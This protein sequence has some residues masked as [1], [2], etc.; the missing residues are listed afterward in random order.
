[1]ESNEFRRDMV[2]LLPR[3]RRFAMTLTR[4]AADA[5]HLVEQACDRAISRNQ[6]WSGDGHFENWL[7]ALTRNVWIDEVRKQKLQASEIDSARSTLD[8]VSQA[9]RMHQMI[10][11]LPEGL[12]TVF[13]LVNVE[14]RSYREAADILKIPVGTVTGRLATARMRLGAMATETTERRA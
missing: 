7:Y 12:A 6:S 4:N 5:D 9:D 2:S 10:L 8:A 14:G 1:M 11:A 3:L 13:L